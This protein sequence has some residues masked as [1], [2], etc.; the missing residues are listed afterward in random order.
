M[1]TTEIQQKKVEKQAYEK[2]TKLATLETELKHVTRNLNAMES[3]RAEMKLQ[4]EKLNQ[5][6]RNLLC[7][8]SS[9]EQKLNEEKDKVAIVRFQNKLLVILTFM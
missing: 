4:A 5:E 2:D 8:N 6:L 7:V 3:E 9:L 1:D